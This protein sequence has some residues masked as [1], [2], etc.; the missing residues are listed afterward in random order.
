MERA[1]AMIDRPEEGRRQSITSIRPRL[2]VAGGSAVPVA[3]GDYEL[4]IKGRLSDSVLAGFEGLRT[5]VQ[6]VETVLY[7]SVQDQAALYGLLDRIQSLGLELVEV[8]QLPASAD[9][10]PAE[11]EPPTARSVAWC[12]ASIWSA[13]DRSSLLTLSA[14]SIQTDPV[15]SRRILWMIKRMI[16]PC[17]AAPSVTQTTA[18]IVERSPDIP[19]GD[20]GWTATRTATGRS[21]RAADYKSIHDR[22]AQ[23]RPH[24]SGRVR[25]PGVAVL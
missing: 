2:D 4:R 19:S 25:R 9:Q 20:A 21:R 16:K 15:G 3:G 22:L 10:V 24:C 5:T 18:G 1:G 12:S 7:G 6:P 8:R 13:P 14:S 23:C 11:P 17:D